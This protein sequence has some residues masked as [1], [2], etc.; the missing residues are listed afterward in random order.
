MSVGLIASCASCAFD[1]LFLYIF[2]FS[3]RYLSP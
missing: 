3:G 1:D 2:G